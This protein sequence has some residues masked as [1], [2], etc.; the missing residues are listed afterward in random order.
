VNVLRH[1]YWL[2]KDSLS[3]ETINALDRRLTKIEAPAPPPERT[4]T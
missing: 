4:M 1:L 3:L 2:A